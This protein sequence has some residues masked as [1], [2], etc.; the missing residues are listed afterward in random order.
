M[1]P[2]RYLAR[3]VCDAPTSARA[4]AAGPCDDMPHNILTRYQLSGSPPLEIWTKPGV[5]ALDFADTS[6]AVLG[7][8]FE[9]GATR[10]TEL[11]PVPW[12]RS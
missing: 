10:A 8:L 11:L 6:G 7:T 9:H 5:N 2:Q 3:I 4:E 1:K 12:T